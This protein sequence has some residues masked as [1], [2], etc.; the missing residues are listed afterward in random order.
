VLA[1]ARNTPFFL[2]LSLSVSLNAALPELSSIEPL[3][4][5]EATQR[6]VARGDARLDFDQTR[7]RADKITYYQAFS[8]AD[9]AGN[10]AVTHEG[11]RLIAD[12]LSF[13]TS[14]SLLSV[15][16]LRTGQ[17]PFY[18][19]GARA[20]GTVERFSIEDARLH[21]GNP[22]PFGL[23]VGSDEIRYEDA[24]GD[25][26]VFVD[27]AV[28]RVGSVPFFY[29][30]SYRHSLTD[31]PYLLEIDG[32]SDD[33]LGTYLQTTSLFPFT[34]G[35]RAGANVDFYSRRGPLFGPAAQY[36]YDSDSQRM[37]GALSTAFIED[38]GSTAELG[39]DIL[40]RPIDSG[41]GFAEWRHQHSIGERFNATASVSYWSDS[42]VARDFRE[43]LFER[44]QRPDNFGEAV[45]AGDNFLI[46]VFGRF[47]PNDFQLVQ[48]RLPEARFDW[49]PTPLLQTGIYQKGSASY[50]QLREDFDAN[51]PALTVNGASDRFDFSYRVERPFRLTD[52][53]TF[54]P[55]AGARVTHY[56]NQSVDPFFLTAPT[57]AENF[58]R[59]IYEFG[60]DLEA[61][62]YASYPTVNETWN[63]DGLRHLVRPSLRYRYF[64]DPDDLNEIATID[65]Q[66]FDLNRPLLDLSDLRNVDQISETH[67]LR[68]GLENIFQTRAEAYG[69]RELA[70]LNFYQDVLFEKGRRFDGGQEN[71]FDTSWI[72]FVLNPAPWLQF[73]LASRFETKRMTLEELL[74]QTTLRSGDLWELSLTT[75]LL[76]KR[77]DQYRIDLIYRLNERYAL[78]SEANLDA[79]TGQVNELSLGLRTRVGS[80]WE[81]LYALTLR[82][83]ARRESD[84]EFQVRLRLANK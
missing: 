41:R 6:L 50:V 57:V 33:Q 35:L 84:L 12:N 9:A 58:T 22:S 73:D 53:L 2:L 31:A 51:A 36:R 7:I 14:E 38:Q 65:R 83:D 46:S 19:S 62:A 5:D 44:N 66:V 67:L 13:D 42:E 47:R 72:E 3:E 1:I 75:N 70:A 11:N 82:E 39:S 37:S 78:L 26:S 15:N 27:G 77:I 24:D 60:F 4:F 81:I 49:L 21:Y 32:G 8:V 52:W 40:R 43:D 16:S 69:S 48:E 23:N 45:Y 29:L 25:A 30:P 63:I 28:F 71:T 68:L 18:I 20:G 59:S 55:L 64:S 61:R 17:W 34:P 74:T 10:I 56:A 54:N 76:N 80:T 79:D